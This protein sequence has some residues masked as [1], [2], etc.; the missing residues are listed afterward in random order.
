MK[1]AGKLVAY[2]RDRGN[3]QRMKRPSPARRL[4]LVKCGATHRES[5]GNAAAEVPDHD[6]NHAPVYT[7]EGLRREIMAAGIDSGRE[8]V[9]K[10]YYS[11]T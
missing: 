11:S 10:P 2:V 3:V 8:H 9:G 7:P 5:Q 6:Y 4:L 1:T